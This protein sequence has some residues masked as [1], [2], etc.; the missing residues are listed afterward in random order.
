MNKTRQELFNEMYNALSKL[1]VEDYPH[2][3]PEDIDYVVFYQTLAF[4]KLGA[5]ELFR[6]VKL[7]DSA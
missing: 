7:F 5:P 6:Y 4:L 3:S 1:H 2:H